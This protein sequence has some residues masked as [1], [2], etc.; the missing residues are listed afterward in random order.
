[1]PT[2]RPPSA[3]RSWQVSTHRSRAACWPHAPPWSCRV[4]TTLLAPGDHNACLFL[5]A[6]GRLLVYLEDPSGKHYLALE[7]GDCVGEMSFIDGGPPRPT[8]SPLRQPRPR[9]RRSACLAPDRTAPA[10]SR[11]TRCGCWPAH[12]RN[13]NAKTDLLTGVH[14]HRWNESR[15]SRARSPGPSMRANRCAHRGR[16]G[17]GAQKHSDPMGDSKSAS[18]R[19]A[20][21]TGCATRSHPARE[22]ARAISLCGCG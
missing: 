19:T 20:R 17:R 8:C 10:S 18:A 3:R 1:M 12:V 21:A 4:G 11:A 5:V 15:C 13:D 16:A 7:S 9:G 22:A 2:A 6:G 14:N